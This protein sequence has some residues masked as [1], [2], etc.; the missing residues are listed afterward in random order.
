MNLTENAKLLMRQRYCRNNEDIIDVFPRV[1]KA[2]G[3]VGDKG[4]EKTFLDMMNNLD[5]L[6][7]SPC[8]MNAGLTNQV[9]ACFVLP[10]ED[11]M[12]SIFT[13]LKNSALIF[14]SGG[15]VGYSFD[16]LRE[17]G[18]SL[19]AGG[20]S[21]GVMSFMH[22]YNSITEAVKAGGTRRG[23]SIGILNYDHPQI[24]DFVTEK[25]KNKTLNNFNLSVMM[26][27]KFMKGLKN[28]EET[29]LHSRRDK[30]RV[31]GRIKNSDLF[32]LI[33]MSAY[34]RGDPGLLFYDRINQDNPYSL[35]NP[36]VAC[37]PC[38]PSDSLLLDGDRLRRIS[39]SNA[40]TWISWKTGEKEVLELECNNGLKL[41]F[42][43]EHKIMLEN[44]EWVEAK[45]SKNKKL[46][47]YYN[48]ER[49]RQ[50]LF[51]E[52]G[53]RDTELNYFI[54][55]KDILKG[56][57][58]GDGFLC[59]NGYGV[60]V[61]INDENEYDISVLLKKFGFYKQRCGVYYI[62]KDKLSEIIDIDFLTY[63][64]FLRYLPKDI[65]LGDENKVAGFLCGLFE[66]NGSISKG[67]QISLKSTCLE[68]IKNVQI[69]LSSFGIP[70]WIVKNKPKKI[71]WK[72]GDYVSKFSYNLQ[73]A[74]T[75]VQLFKDKIAFYNQR[76][77]S[78]IKPNYRI[79]KNKLKVIN[80]KSLGIM[81]V[82]D[83]NMNKSPHHN[84]CQGIIAKNCAE[85]PLHSYSSCC[86]GSINLNN[87]I[88]NGD[89]NWSKFEYIIDNSTKF[90][91]AMNKICEFPL[92]QCYI[93]QGKYNP[94]GL[95]LMG[96][97]DALIKMSIIY[98]SKDTLKLIDRICKIMKRR[99][100]KIASNS[101]T[102]LSIA[103]TGSLSILANC[104]ASIEPIFSKNYTRNL[105]IGKITE[106]RNDNEYLRLAHDISPIWHL[107]VQAKFQKYV[108]S[109]VSKTINLP[110]DSSLQDVKDIYYQSWKMGC[111]GITV[112]RDGCLDNQVYTKAPTC[113]GESC[114]L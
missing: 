72:N 80:I 56:F 28:G 88:E 27:D 30:R 69:L 43:S 59:G 1:A 97:A 37:N 14:K 99:T 39:D 11:T 89:I 47:W 16:K 45:N 112:F 76:K 107:K 65:L 42:T 79:Y 94:I 49:G 48:N 67:N 38:Q 84:F 13:T 64:V 4:D 90:L 60:S 85:Q 61:K 71:S 114:N 111:K 96:F 86:L 17:R 109:G 20:T 74:P 81:E 12:N 25:L 103:P 34:M 53:N 104:S 100:K 51:D 95:G 35:E 22:I 68:M 8:L 26:D 15:G 106:S 33:C 10:I 50:I 66:A 32:G 23:A 5:F 3:K 75:N 2:L 6:P 7:N 98:D 54:D 57:L 24:I 70:S 113:E 73:I 110:Y 91:L 77:N 9:K 93:I 105:T 44:D 31:T 101:I 21:S 52:F 36:I 108:D 46:K 58:F 55:D 83:Y 41:R 63:R 19:S 40:K 92:D 29:I 102:T 87:M 78:K 62:N 82:W 18:S